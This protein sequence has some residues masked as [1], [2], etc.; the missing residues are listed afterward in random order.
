VK[1]Q[2][3][4]L[5]RVRVK[6]PAAIASMIETQSRTLD[7]FYDKLFAKINSQSQ[8]DR[9]IA[10]HVF[11]W[12]MYSGQRITFG[13]IAA[14]FTVDWKTRSIDE[15]KR[16]PNLD[17]LLLVC[18][19]LVVSDSIEHDPYLPPPALPFGVS[20]PSADT[21]RYLRFV[22]MSVP[23]YI[24]RRAESLNPF[25]SSGDHLLLSRLQA[26]TEIALTS[27]TYFCVRQQPLL[28]LSDVPEDNNLQSKCE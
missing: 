11:M 18:E 9:N 5:K 24:R 19:N 17:D 7:E 2:L 22:H 6:S 3:E 10:R 20:A 16:P 1:L 28:P 23:D 14:S 27:I 26:S 15:T 12:L 25:C 8:C 21:R 13:D 4:Q